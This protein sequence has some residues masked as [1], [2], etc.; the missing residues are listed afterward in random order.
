MRPEDKIL[1]QMRSLFFILYF[2]FV[3][4][5]PRICVSARDE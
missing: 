2:L 1:D 3:I 4:F 5:S